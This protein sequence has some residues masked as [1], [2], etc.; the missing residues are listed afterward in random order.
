MAGKAPV[1][2]RAQNCSLIIRHIMAASV[3][4]S[5]ACESSVWSRSWSGSRP[6]RKAAAIV[7]RT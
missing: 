5:S 7:V 2:P 1:W 3:S 6:R 4:Y